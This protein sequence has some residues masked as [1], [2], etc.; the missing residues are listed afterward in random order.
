[1][2]GGETLWITLTTGILKNVS[3]SVSRFYN[4]NEK[5]SKNL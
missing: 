4:E 2:V 1:M 5:S 3:Q